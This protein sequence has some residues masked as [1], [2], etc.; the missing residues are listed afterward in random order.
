MKALTA[1]QWGRWGVSTLHALAL[2]HAL[3]CGGRD[4][5]TD[6][7]QPRHDPPPHA[8]S[9]PPR[10]EPPPVFGPGEEP[11]GDKVK[12]CVAKFVARLDRLTGRDEA[13]EAG[14]LIFLNCTQ[15]R[16]TLQ[17]ALRH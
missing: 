5:G 7:E 12:D 14:R 15:S 2:A 4:G 6:A 13:F 16:D 9:V 11:G 8:P 17:R 3:S 1:V 10:E